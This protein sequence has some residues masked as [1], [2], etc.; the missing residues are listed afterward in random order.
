MTDLSSSG[1]IFVRTSTS[2]PGV[3]LNI[4]IP[5]GERLSLISIRFMSRFLLM[6]MPLECGDLFPIHLFKLPNGGADILG[7]DGGTAPEAESR[8]RVLV[9]ARV[10]GDLPFSQFAGDAFEE[11]RLFLF[12]KRPDFVADH[13]EPNR[14][15]GA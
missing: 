13:G 5:S 3:F 6:F 14:C 12:R 8:R 1:V 4:S 7:V 15:A 11:F 9:R 2:I 10:V